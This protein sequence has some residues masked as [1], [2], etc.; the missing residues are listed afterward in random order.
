MAVDIEKE[1]KCA[2]MFFGEH[3]EKA[4]KFAKNL[5][6]KSEELGLLGPRELSVLWSRHIINSA[7]LSTKIAS[8]YDEAKKVIADI[9]SGAGFPGIVLAITHPEHTFFFVE[10]MERRSVWLREQIQ[11]LDLHNVSVLRARA[12]QIHGEYFFDI[13]TSR[14]VSSFQNLVKITAPLLKTEGEMMFLKGER[15]FEEINQA[16]KEILK[17]KLINVSVQEILTPYTEEK[18]RIIYAKKEKR[19]T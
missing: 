3:L 12:E 1:P 11:E 4:K 15:A 8:S 16:K 13:V 10:P 9:G 19:F 17:H 7:L 14:A 6:Q 18:A 5:I 2:E